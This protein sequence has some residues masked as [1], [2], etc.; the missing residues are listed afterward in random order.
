MISDTVLPPFPH[1]LLSSSPFSIL[2]PAVGRIDATVDV[3]LHR[4]LALVAALA[5]DGIGPEHVDEADDSHAD[6][7]GGEA[8]EDVK[9]LGVRV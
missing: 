2:P 1:K 4:A 7:D 5:L 3:H 8:K 9:V 6:G